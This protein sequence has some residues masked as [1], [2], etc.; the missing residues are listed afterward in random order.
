MKRWHWASNL[1]SDSDSDV[2]FIGGRKSW[3]G[4]ELQRFSKSWNLVRRFLVMK[5]A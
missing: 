5:G 1:D 2:W 4:M 3:S